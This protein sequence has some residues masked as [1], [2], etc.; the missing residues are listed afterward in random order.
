M[1]VIKDVLFHNNMTCNIITITIE[2]QRV[3]ILSMRFNLYTDDHHSISGVDQ[4]D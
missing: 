2:F 3:A 4:S 1:S